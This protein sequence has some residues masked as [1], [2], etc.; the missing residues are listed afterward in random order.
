MYAKERRRLERFDIALPARIAV[1]EGGQRQQVISLT[2][3]NISAGGAFFKTDAPLPLGTEV[4]VELTLLAE[5]F[6]SVTPNT[7]ALVRMAGRVL[8]NETRGMAI[9]FSE[10]FHMQAVA[11]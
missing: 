2:T 7:E 11:C 8:R 4:V 9:A 1:A 3:S 10:K 6:K 5:L